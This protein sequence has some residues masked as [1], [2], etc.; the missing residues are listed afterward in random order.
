MKI[1]PINSENDVFGI[2]NRPL[3]SVKV[4]NSAGECSVHLTPEGVEFFT[5]AQPGHYMLNTPGQVDPD[6]E[7]AVASVTVKDGAVKVFTER[8]TPELSVGSHTLVAQ[9]HIAF[10]A[11]VLDTSAGFSN[12]EP[13]AGNA[14]PRP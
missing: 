10:H 13:T 11:S 14:S 5:H 12:N 2:H 7:T 3:G 8:Y 9:S 4:N 6:N 1:T